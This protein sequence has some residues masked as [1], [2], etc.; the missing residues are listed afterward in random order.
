MVTV[1]VKFGGR[2]FKLDPMTFGQMEQIFPLVGTLKAGGLPALL[3]IM[4]IVISEGYPSVDVRKMPFDQAGLREA[5]NQAMSI[6]GLV[7]TATG[8]GEA[9]PGGVPAGMKKSTSRKSAPA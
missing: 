7:L 5:F 2:E 8:V 9:A 1:K 6:S 4:Q 3:D